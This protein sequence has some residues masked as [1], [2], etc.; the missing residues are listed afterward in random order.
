M[1]PFS[2][3]VEIRKQ[4][5]Q[6]EQKQQQSGGSYRAATKVAAKNIATYSYDLH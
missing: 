4:V 6:Q 2:K 1:K 5:P 3:K